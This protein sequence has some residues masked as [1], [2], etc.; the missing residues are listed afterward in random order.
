M[1]TRPKATKK[2]AAKKTA[3]AKSPRAQKVGSRRKSASQ[4]LNDL[5]RQVGKLLAE[6]FPSGTPHG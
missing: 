4:R 6:T 2:K 5:E 3:A 1:A